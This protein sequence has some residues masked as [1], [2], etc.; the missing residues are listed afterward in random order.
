[1][2]ACPSLTPSWMELQSQYGFSLFCVLRFGGLGW[3]GL[4]VE[5]R[6]PIKIAVQV[7]DV[8][9]L[10]AEATSNTFQQP[11]IYNSDR[12]LIFQFL[13][14]STQGDEFS[15]LLCDHLPVLVQHGIHS[16]SRHFLLAFQ[17]RYLCGS[18]RW[19][20][21]RLIFRVRELHP[22]FDLVCHDVGFI[23]C[24]V[25]VGEFLWQRNQNNSV[26]I[27]GLGDKPFGLPRMRRFARYPC[28]LLP[29]AFLQAGGP[30]IKCCL[31]SVRIGMH[32]LHIFAAIPP[33]VESFDLF[34]T[35]HGLLLWLK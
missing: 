35:Q 33:A 8:H 17:L 34:I 25:V 13:D 20:G 15:I 3:C 10:W 21:G 1:M 14:S 29:S 9:Q 24:F 11:R 31:P 30:A 28:W 27:S 2:T 7:R 18:V 4:E 23:G 6:S 16:K 26:A 12:L 19:G 22:A 5:L 32:D